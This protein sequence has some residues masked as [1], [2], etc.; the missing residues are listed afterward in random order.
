[1]SFNLNTSRT[2]C[3]PIRIEDAPAVFNYRSD[4]ETNRYQGFIPETSEEVEHWIE[5]SAG[6]PFEQADSW[7][8]LIVIE[9]ESGVVIGDLGIHFPADNPKQFEFGLTLNK[10][11]HGRGF[12]REI[13]HGLFQHM[14]EQLGYHRVFVSIDKDNTASIKLAEAL[15]MRKEAHFVKSLFWKDE[16]VDDV[17]YALLGEEFLAQL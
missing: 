8:Q 11:F 13:A 5:R 9:Q 7:Y 10:E 1:M 2:S 14:F 15:G 16:W 17:I 12:A 3:R 6:I 4:K